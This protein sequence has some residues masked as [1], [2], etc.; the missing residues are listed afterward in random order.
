MNKYEMVLISAREA[1]RL[2]ELARLSSRELKLRPTL[3]AWQRLEQGKI[4]YT[5]EVEKIEAEPD[6]IPADAGAAP[7][8]APAEEGA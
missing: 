6:L 2:N 5:Y 8:G 3:L 7:L 1:R 4:K